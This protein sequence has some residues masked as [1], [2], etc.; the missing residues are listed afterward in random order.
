M[1]NTDFRSWAE[2]AWRKAEQMAAQRESLLQQSRDIKEQVKRADLS[3]GHPFREEGY[4]LCDVANR[5]ANASGDGEAKGYWLVQ[6]QKSKA[7][8]QQAYNKTEQE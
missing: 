8:A 2:Q 5:I 7:Q 4:H 3:P 6:V 1:T